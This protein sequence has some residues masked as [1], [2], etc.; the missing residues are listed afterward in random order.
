MKSL[1]ILKRVQQFD[2]VGVAARD[3]RECLLL[4]LDSLSE[5]TPWLAQARSLVDLHLDLLGSKDFATL[6]RRTGLSEHELSQV[7]AL[8]RTLQPRP[9][10]ALLAEQSDY[11]IPDVLVRKK[12]T[13]AG[14]A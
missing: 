4:Q 12:R 13:M 7:V 3:I 5:E 8:I 6:V 9:G 14:R 11:E 2:P 1:E 10:A